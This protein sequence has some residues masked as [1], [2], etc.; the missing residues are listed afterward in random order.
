MYL[1]ARVNMSV[2]PFRIIV[3]VILWTIV[4]EKAPKVCVH[5]AFHGEI[6]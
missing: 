4:E 1:K 6:Q 5:V 2:L 3:L